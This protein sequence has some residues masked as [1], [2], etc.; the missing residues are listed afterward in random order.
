MLGINKISLSLEE[1]N[2]LLS[3]LLR[4]LDREHLYAKSHMI[5]NF[6]KDVLERWGDQMVS[7]LSHSDCRISPREYLQAHRM[8]LK[9]D[10]FRLIKL[11]HI[12]DL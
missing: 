1:M 6:L 2:R 9:E 5:E 3:Q 4:S 8:E 10:V 12:N 11:M 7:E